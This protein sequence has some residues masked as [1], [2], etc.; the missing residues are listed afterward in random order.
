MVFQKSANG[1][2]E[3]FAT[4]AEPT[5]PSVKKGS[6]IS[7]RVNVTEHKKDPRKFRGV[8][9][10]NG[11][12]ILLVSDSK[13]A[14][15][16]AAFLVNV[17][18]KSDPE[19][20]KG[21]AH[22]CEHVLTLGATEKYPKDGGSLSISYF[23][24]NSNAYTY[25]DHTTY[26]VQARIENFKDVLDHILQIFISPQITQAVVEREIDM[27]HSEWMFSNDTTFDQLLREAMSRPEDFFERPN[28][29]NRHTLKEVPQAKGIDVV[30]EVRNFFHNY[31]SANIMTCCLITPES[32]D[33]MEA[34]VESMD[35]QKIPNT[36]AP[37]VGFELDLESDFEAE[38]FAKCL[39]NSTFKECV[40]KGR[41][42]VKGK[43]DKHFRSQDLVRK[44]TNAMTTLSAFKRQKPT[45]T[46][47]KDTI[48]IREESQIIQS[49]DLAK[50]HF[51][52]RPGTEYKIR[53]VFD[54][55]QTLSETQIKESGQFLENFKNCP[56]EA[57]NITLDA[58]EVAPNGLFM[59]IHNSAPEVKHPMKEFFELF[60]NQPYNRGYF[61]IADLLYR[62]FLRLSFE[63][64]A[65]F[66]EIQ[67]LTETIFDTLEKVSLAAKK[68]KDEK[69]RV[70]RYSDNRSL[71]SGALIVIQVDTEAPKQVA[72]MKLLTRFMFRPLKYAIRIKHVLGY[73]GDIELLQNEAWKKLVIHVQG[74]RNPD[75]MLECLEKVMK[76]FK[77]NLTTMS[78]EEFQKGRTAA[79]RTVD[80]ICGL[81]VNIVKKEIQNCTKAELLEFYDMNIAPESLNDRKSVVLIQGICN[82]V[83]KNFETSLI[84]HQETLKFI[85]NSKGSKCPKYAKLLDL[86]RS[87]LNFRP[88]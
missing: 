36:N 7:N 33:E 23:D 20:V 6:S 87:Y 46:A 30:Q 70:V 27:I 25:N 57:D 42:K 45:F 28:F 63:G 49:D 47:F 9:L 85:E 81:D 54:F 77:A 69:T 53:L 73:H 31:Y 62:S 21:L 24:G 4:Y 68:V 37:V 32:L 50:V 41:S 14:I 15:S 16:Q 86:F 79:E 56:K 3:K 71:Q 38:K 80:E 17:G 10:S 59:H 88:S 64:N 72:L 52:Q 66:G 18:S 35:F 22:L 12:R 11:L 60:S 29:G 43:I 74:E 82:E 44:L 13:I 75:Y 48:L 84:T 76:D 83:N 1:N 34:L 40:E 55:P 5:I 78:L 67:K 8:K 2:V 39:V 61:C 51:L 19:D 65:V 26:R 58:F